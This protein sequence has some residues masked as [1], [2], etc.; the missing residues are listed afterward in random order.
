MRYCFYIGTCLLLIIF[1]TTV[2]SYF[3]V[4][5]GIYD[6]LIPFVIFLSISLPVRECLPFILIL[7]F[8]VDSLSGSPF[9]LYL[10]FYF[11]L[12]VG[13]RWSIKYLR[14]GNKLFLSL[15]VIVAVLI[16][17]ILVMGTFAVFGPV[18][19]LPAEAFRSIAQ[20]TFWALFTGP[21]FLFSLLA[22]SKRF[23]IQINGAAA[24]PK[25]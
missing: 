4:T 12:L 16:E 18:G 11:W 5:R 23:N 21:L 6:L 19:Q 13:I 3:N 24:A 17:N 14:A 10:T 25:T 20:Q 8:I 9:G 1:Q 7:G 15:V 22:I 2:L